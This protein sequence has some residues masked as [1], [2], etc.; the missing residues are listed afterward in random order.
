MRSFLLC[1]ACLL[2]PLAAR[3]QSVDE[4]IAA[5]EAGRIDDAQA[6]LEAIV[7]RGRAGPDDLHRVHLHLGILA[8]VMGETDRAERAWRLALALRPATETPAELAPAQRAIFE[9]LRAQAAALSVRA[10]AVGAASNEA[11]TTVRVDVANAP[12][13][14]VTQIRSLATPASGGAPWSATVG[15]GEPTELAIPAIAWRAATRLDVVIEALDAHG[16]VLAR[17]ELTLRHAQASA[18]HPALAT[19]EAPASGG[20]SVVEEA[21]F[22][23]V[24]G[25]LVLGGAA[26]GIGLALTLGPEQYVLEGPTIER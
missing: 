7:A 21:W 6:R 10:A 25:A 11:A 4:A 16:G 12:D 14:S 9:R 20:G 17:T 8:A 24:I 3:A 18:A 23:V 13:G 19:G 2:A 22:W 1:V 26:L 15:A 5:Y